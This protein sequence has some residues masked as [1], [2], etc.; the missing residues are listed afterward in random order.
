MERDGAVVYT[1]TFAGHR[2]VY[3]SEVRTR[4][5]EE[6][7]KVATKYD[8]ILFY[9]GGIGDFD[10]MC[11]SEVRALKRRHPKQDIKLV[12]VEPY[13]KQSINEEGEYLHMMYDEILIPMELAGIH[14]KKAITERN[15]W[16]IR[17]SDLL[18]AYVYREFGGAYATLKFARKL[19]KECLNLADEMQ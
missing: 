19:G 4:L 5:A 10:G 17:E 8:S 1:V 7:E 11:A 16:M 9:V 6:L 14:Y 18:V 2:E 12:L 3:Q 13:M 15:R